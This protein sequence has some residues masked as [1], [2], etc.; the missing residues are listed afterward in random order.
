MWC[1][2]PQD[3]I[4]K[5]FLK[6][7][8]LSCN[9]HY[10]GTLVHALIQICTRRI[11]WSAVGRH[12]CIA[13]LKKTLVTLCGCFWWT[14]SKDSAGWTTLSHN[15]LAS[16]FLLQVLREIVVRP[17]Q[18]DCIDDLS[19]NCPKKCW[20][21]VS[22]KTSSTIYRALAAWITRCMWAHAFSLDS[23]FSVSNLCGLRCRSASGAVAL[24]DRARFGIQQPFSGQL[25]FPQL[26]HSSS[27][28]CKTT[29]GRGLQSC[30]S[31]STSFFGLVLWRET[32]DCIVNPGL[33]FKPL[34]EVLRTN[35]LT[36]LGPHPG[37]HLDVYVENISL[38]L[39]CFATQQRKVPARFQD[40]SGF[41]GR[42]FSC[43]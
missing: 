34:T 32:L 28:M 43:H 16:V 37:F 4:G 30:W 41:S 8:A 42:A 14:L 26:W 25:E 40:C 13:C 7:T 19:T 38:A 9:K 29:V 18:A 36:S 1:N 39:Q 31:S 23:F 21:A 17:L 2:F 27:F 11:R 5:C 24:F 20:R 6:C 35:Q 3:A 33:N 10:Y 22:C 12:S 15:S